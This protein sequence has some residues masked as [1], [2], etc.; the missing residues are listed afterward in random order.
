MLRKRLSALIGALALA[1]VLGIIV[2]QVTLGSQA[3]PLG[4]A[5]PVSTGLPDREAGD[6]IESPTISSIDSH[7]PM[8]YR[9][10][11]GSGACYIQWNYLNVTAASGAYVISM[12]VTIDDHL[13]A[14]HSGFFQTSMYIPGDM[15][16]PGYKVTCGVPGS[17]DKAEWGN[18]YTYVIR[19]RD[20]NGLKAANYGSVT[21]PADVV[22]VFSPF[23][24]K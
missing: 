10:V 2:V 20:T 13:R 11:E 1:G 16:A 14:Y 19:A 8:C 15:T 21:C 7:S 24:R 17:G 22:N 12:T 5:T 18:T 9:P 6:D 4:A 3:A 23:L